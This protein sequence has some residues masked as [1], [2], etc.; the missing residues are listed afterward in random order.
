MITMEKIDYVISVTGASYELV[1]EALLSCDGDVDKAI[2]KIMEEHGT[3]A[4]ASATGKED[5]DL[6]DKLNKLAQEISEG[7]KEIVA[8]G[9]ATRL[10]VQDDKGKEIVNMSL[11]LGTLGTVFAP[12]LVLIGLGVGLIAKCNFYV[13]LKDGQRID[14]KDY[15]KHR[16]KKDSDQDQDPQA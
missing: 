8:T 7:I 12:H 5:K 16:A 3:Q 14:V 11:T 9:N 6:G 4:Q 2:E 13:Y 15:L 10:E 1:R